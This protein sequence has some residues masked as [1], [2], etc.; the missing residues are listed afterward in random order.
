MKYVFF[1][2]L[3]ITGNL[4]SNYILVSVVQFSVIV[5]LEIYFAAKIEKL[6]ELDAM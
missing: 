1:L 2:N 3:V 5:N 6:H 4:L